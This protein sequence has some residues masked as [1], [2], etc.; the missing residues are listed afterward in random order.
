MT[1][2]PKRPVK[3][4]LRLV[5]RVENFNPVHCDIVVRTNEP[6]AVFYV[7]TPNH[8]APSVVPGQLVVMLDRN[9]GD[10]FSRSN[11]VVGPARVF[12]LLQRGRAPVVYVMAGVEPSR[13]VPR[14]QFMQ[15]M[16]EQAKLGYS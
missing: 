14:E 9:D 3:K 12:S 2:P 16:R 1:A 8:I 4:L 7:P 6:T 11:A 5:G 15:Q 10:G 13:P